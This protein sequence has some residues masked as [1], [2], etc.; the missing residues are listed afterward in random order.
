MNKIFWGKVKTFLVTYK[1][2]LGGLVILAVLIGALAIGVHCLFTIKGTVTR[3]DPNS[4]A[5]TNFFMTRTV[6]LSGSPV[7]AANIKIGDRVT[8]RESLQGTI[9]SIQTQGKKGKREHK[10]PTNKLPGLEGKPR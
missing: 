4:I 2:Q 3:V 8:I 1:K 9:L 6:D 5:V 7:S 10:K